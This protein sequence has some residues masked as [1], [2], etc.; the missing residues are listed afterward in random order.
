VNQT[1]FDFEQ[2]LLLIENEIKNTDFGTIP[3]ELYEPIRYLMD[4]GGKR[5]RPFLVM[6]GSA[7]FADHWQENVKAALAVEVFHNFTLM[8]DDIMDN[9]PIRR[10]KPTVHEK[11]NRNIALLSGDVMLVRAYQQLDFVS[12]RYF[13]TVLNKFH[14]CA[15]EVCEGQQYDMNFEQLATVT[16]QEYINMIRLK[17]AVLLGFSLEFGAIIGGASVE[18]AQ[19]LYDFGV[20]IGIG[21]QLK[22]DLLDVYSEQEKFG[23]QVGGD[24]IANKKTFLLI[25]ALEK[26]N[27]QTKSDLEKWLSAIHFDKT[28]K[29]EAVIG[30]YKV[31]QIR[32]ITEEKMN[33]YFSKAFSL[34]EELDTIPEKKEI[35][36][37]FTTDLLNREK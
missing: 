17:T 1:N 37:K 29:V 34:L 23:K 24:I 9:A 15:A 10:G 4:L 7:L 27:G 5:I 25:K 19:K 3:T 35:L 12:D 20:N 26:A 8:H 6:M 18:N 2:T 22:D 13:K 32:E 14:Q 31:L 28:E 30:I 16:E 36:L 11:W 33:S 21:F